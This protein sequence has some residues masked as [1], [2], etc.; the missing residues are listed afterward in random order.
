M[1]FTGGRLALLNSTQN[2][3]TLNGTMIP[4]VKFVGSPAISLTIQATFADLRAAANGTFE[5]SL[6]GSPIDTVPLHNFTGSAVASESIRLK[7][8]PYQLVAALTLRNSAASSNATVSSWFNVTSTYTSAVLTYNFGNEVLVDSAGNAS[9]SVHALTG[10]RLA[11][12]TAPAGYISGQFT[13]TVYCNTLSIEILQ[14]E[15]LRVSEPIQLEPNGGLHPP[16]GLEVVIQIGLGVPSVLG[17]SYVT[18]GTFPG[19]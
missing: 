9:Y 6:D 7:P 13:V 15:S 1:I 11:S 8:G 5:L 3:T 14:N 16:F 17:P 12:G 2:Q 4:R 19:I 18:E 10:K